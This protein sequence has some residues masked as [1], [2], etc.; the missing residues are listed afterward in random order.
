MDDVVGLQKIVQHLVAAGLQVPRILHAA[1]HPERQRRAEDEGIVLAEI[2]REA[3][4]STFDVA[5]LDG[6]EDLQAWH[7]LARSEDR[8]LEL[9]VGEL[10]DALGDQFGATVERVERAGPAGRQPPL[11]F[12]IGLRDR[13]CREARTR[14]A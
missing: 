6:I 1:R 8:Q 3:R 2:V 7:D 5:G 14:G 11:D 10:C 9:V 13:R 4:M 12:G